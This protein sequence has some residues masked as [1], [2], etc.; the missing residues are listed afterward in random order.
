MTKEMA[1]RYWHRQWLACEDDPTIVD[2][3]SL[4]GI[5]EDHGLNVQMG[6]GAGFIAVFRNGETVGLSSWPPEEA[7]P[8]EYVL[9]TIQF[10][11]DTASEYASS[12][13]G[14]SLENELF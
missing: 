3:D 12:K 1:F 5:E 8:D 2:N 10:C 14:M 9:Y 7:D 11:Y 6:M 4:C 13:L